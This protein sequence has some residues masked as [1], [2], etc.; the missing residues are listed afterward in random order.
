MPKSGATWED[1]AIQY[2]QDVI[3]YYTD[4]VVL[5][6]KRCFM[7]KAYISNLVHTMRFWNNLH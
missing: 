2:H 6:V 4:E 1:M 3:I 5:N 7:H